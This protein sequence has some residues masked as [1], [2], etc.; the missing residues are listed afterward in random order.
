MLMCKLYDK[1]TPCYLE[2]STVSQARRGASW[3]M[4]TLLI[5]N[6]DY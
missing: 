6:E 5:Q 3:L 1:A 4:A 2:Q